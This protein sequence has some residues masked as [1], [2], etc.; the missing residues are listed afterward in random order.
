MI[1]WLKYFPLDLRF[2]DT[3]HEADYKELT[4]RQA[5]PIRL[6][7]GGNVIRLWAPRH[8]LFSSKPSTYLRFQDGM[9]M[10]FT[11][12]SFA[13]TDNWKESTLLSRWMQYQYSWFRGAKGTLTMNMAIVTRAPKKVFVNTSF[14]HPRSFEFILSNYLNTQYGHEHDSKGVARYTAPINWQVHQQLPVFS[15]SFDVEGNNADFCYFFPISDIHFIKLSFGFIEDDQKLKEEM[16][17]LAKEIIQS[18]TLELGSQSQTQWDRVKDECPD[19]SLSESFAP[20]QWPIKPEDI[21]KSPVV[22]PFI[23]PTEQLE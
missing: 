7:A 3:D 5:K 1:D 21:E 13:A 4:F 19:M 15:V 14:F 2:L 20:L 18:V 17:T 8:S 12:Y 11:N 10:I 16:K 23:A 6:L 22:M 9:D